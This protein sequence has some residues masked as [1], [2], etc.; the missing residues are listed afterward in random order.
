MA[1]VKMIPDGEAVGE[2]KQA[3][4]RIREKRGLVAN[5]VRIS[6]LIPEVME[7]NIDFY[8]AVMYGK[9]K[10]PRPQREMVAVEVSRAN[11]CDYCVNHHGAALGRVLRDEPA[12]KQFMQSGSM[13]LLTEKDRTMLAY[14]RKLALA[15]T[16]CGPADVE[17]LRSAGFDDEEIIA[18]NHIVGYFSLM[19]RVVLGL[20]VELEA[21]KGAAPQYQ[22]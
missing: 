3:Y 13:R 6:G 4:A 14:A 2:L 5:V 12:A 10:L 16:Q 21:D 8:M 11:R 1:W 22:Y 7:R 18:I 15:P 19:N 9:H 17:S 20:G